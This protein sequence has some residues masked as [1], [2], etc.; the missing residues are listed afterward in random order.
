MPTEEQA[1]QIF[2]IERSMFS[3]IVWSPLSLL[4]SVDMLWYVMRMSPEMDRNGLLLKDKTALINTGGIY[5]WFVISFFY[6]TM[7]SLMMN[8]VYFICRDYCL[9]FNELICKI[10]TIFK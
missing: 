7:T 3:R 4:L 8:V 1:K 10:K 6:M 5:L 9:F 2:T